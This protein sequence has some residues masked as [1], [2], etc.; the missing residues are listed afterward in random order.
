[1]GVWAYCG[2]LGNFYLSNSSPRIADVGRVELAYSYPVHTASAT[3]DEP[4]LLNAIRFRAQLA[5]SAHRK[6]HSIPI[7]LL[8]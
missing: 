1:M 5:A 3:F 8:R 6:Q 2:P 7:L 4:A